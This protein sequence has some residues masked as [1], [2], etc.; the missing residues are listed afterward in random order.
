LTVY[1]NGGMNTSYSK[2]FFDPT[3]GAN[4]GKLGVDLIQLIVAPT[5]AYKIADNHSIGVS[6]LLVYQR[7]QAYGLQGFGLNP[8]QG[9]D[10]SMGLGIRVGYQGR[11][12]DVLTVG[13]S[14]SPKIN[15]GRFDRYANLFAESG[16]FDIPENYTFGLSIQATPAVQLA[17]DFQRINYSKVRS[18]GNTG[19]SLQ[20]LG[21]PD[22]P[23]F[24]WMDVNVV[25]L[26]VQWKA[27]EQ[28]T[29]RA[30]YNHGDNPIK[31]AEITFNV[32]APGVV[33]S[34][35]TVGATYSPTKTE[36]WSF[37]YMHAKKSAVNGPFNGAFPAEISMSQNGIGIQY[38]RKF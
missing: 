19:N 26:G 16:D 5:V 4:F 14:Y 17:L 34:H 30:G 27:S 25:K 23:G 38:S 20:P 6:P 33:K 7:F 1:G 13:G 2:N 24:G 3:L 37:A 9:T 36:E 18:I 11:L 32:L 15:M 28:W 12:N 22:G 29:F 35:V 21:L 10:D 8:N 31:P